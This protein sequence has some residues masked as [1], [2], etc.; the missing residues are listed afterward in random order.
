MLSQ[1]CVEAALMVCRY[2]QPG[3]TFRR[4]LGCLLPSGEH[5]VSRSKAVGGNSLWIGG[6]VVSGV[7]VQRRA[8]YQPPPLEP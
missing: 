2:L 7:Y 6:E 1:G 4:H 8:G 5:V 3:D